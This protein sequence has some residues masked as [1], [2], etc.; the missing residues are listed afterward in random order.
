MSK[1]HNRFRADMTKEQIDQLQ[2]TEIKAKRTR[3]GKV[4]ALGGNRFQAITYTDPVHRYNAGTREWEEIDNRFSATPRMQT[5]RASWQRG[6]MPAL[7]HGEPLLECKTGNMDI[8]CSMSGEEPFITLTDTE[9]RKLA[10]GIEGA[11]SILPEAEQPESA[12]ENHVRHMR[13]KVL[14][15]LHGE[16]VYSGIFAGVDLRCKL[17]RGFK[18]ELVFVEKES[19]RPVTFLLQSEGR[20]MEL[21]EDH[22]LVVKD[23][24]G[25][26]VF[27][28]QAP[29]LMDANEQRGLVDVRLDA[30]ENGVYALVYTP[31]ASFVS[32]AAFPVVLD[33]AV[34][35]LQGEEAIEDTYVK[36][37]SSAVN[38][39]SEQI[40]V[41]MM[42][43]ATRLLLPL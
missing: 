43:L 14:E 42:L 34:E 6:I 13:E 31:D 20:Q 1:K 37:G 28:L 36:E 22:A 9:G 23:A 7:S 39:S 10:W 15:H 21:T 32:R 3:F 35:S 19:V 27:R 24:Q 16:V 30:R 40:W 38:K 18:D 29:F 5:V 25:A 41:F 11:M 4:Y 12:M 33:P 8:D 17:D 26:V 2:G